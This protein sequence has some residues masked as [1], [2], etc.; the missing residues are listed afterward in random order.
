MARVGFIGCGRHATKMLYPSLRLARL[1]LA[2]V[3][4]LNEDL[5]RRNARWFGAERHYTDYRRMLDAEKLDAILICT[6]PGTHAML[7]SECIQRGLPTFVEKPPA[8]SLAEAEQLREL[9][10]AA[11]VPVMVGMMK[12][13]AL[14]YRRL[15]RI[16]S[17]P[18][19][20]HVAAVQAK[21]GIGWKNGNGYAV[22]LDA[23]IHMIDL[24]RALLGEVVDLSCQKSEPEPTHVSYA[25]ALRFAGGAVGSLLISD[26]HSWTRANERVEVTGRGQFA[27]ADNL[28][29]LEHCRPSGE[30]SAWEPGFSIP[31]DENLGYFLQGY[32]GELL[33]FAEVVEGRISPEPGLA[34]ACQDLKLIKSIEPDDTY[35]KGPQSFEHWASENRW[36]N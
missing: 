19:F 20:G 31:N 14:I 16:I 3:C 8:S 30:I 15:R 24:L 11:G 13:H 27:V 17:A 18:D 7:V 34:D 12:R 25:V 29:R 10:A 2:A 22:L 6:G 33:A 36:L 26:D 28:I 1:E 23:G 5:A 4:D 32:A 9:S 35:V 21:F